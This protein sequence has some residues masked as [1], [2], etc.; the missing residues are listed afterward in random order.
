MQICQAFTNLPFS[1]TPSAI[2]RNIEA[3][4][5]IPTSP[6]SGLSLTGVYRMNPENNDNNPSQKVFAV[7]WQSLF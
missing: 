3:N 7:R 5:F 6:I 2:E 4:Y 1:I